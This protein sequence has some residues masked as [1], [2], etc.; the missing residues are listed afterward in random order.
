M[1]STTWSANLTK[2]IEPPLSEMLDS[3]TD[4]TMTSKLLP[5]PFCGSHE[6]HCGLSIICEGCGARCV[7][8][9]WNTRASQ[10]RDADL[11]GLLPLEPTKEMAVAGRKALAIVAD[12]ME[13]AKLLAV[14][15]IDFWQRVGHEPANEIYKAMV[16]AAPRQS[17]ATHSGDGAGGR[18]VVELT[19]SELNDIATA[20]FGEAAEKAKAFRADVQAAPD[21]SVRDAVMHLLHNDDRENDYPI[22]ET[23]DDRGLEEAEYL[24][25]AFDLLAALSHPSTATITPPGESGGDPNMPAE[26]YSHPSA[27]RG[28]S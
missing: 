18:S 24:Q 20:A 5:C 19:A 1:L 17:S 22:Y 12:R 14:S 2:N 26:G 13:E 10:P 11:S 28:A 8:S 16:E 27:D 23:D 21:A 25:F 6:L 9:L 7:T 15:S 3:M 4:Q